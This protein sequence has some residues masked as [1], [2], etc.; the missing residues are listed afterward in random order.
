V[1][2]GISKVVLAEN[3]IMSTPS[4][5]MLVRHLGKTEEC[6]GV[7]ILTASHNPGREHEDLGIKFNNASGT[8][9]QRTSQVSYL[10]AVRR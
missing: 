7:I 6:F 3:G 8:P 4:V 10:S 1:G 5:S 2:N 9:L